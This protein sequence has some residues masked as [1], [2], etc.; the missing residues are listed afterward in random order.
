MENKFKFTYSAKEQEEIRKIRN[1]Y[2]HTVDDEDKISTLRRLDRQV[3]SKATMYSL[4]VGIIG[5]LIMGTGMSLILTDVAS[6]LGAVLAMI[7]GILIGVAGIILVCL[8]YPTYNYIIKKERAK[9]APEIIRLTDE[10]I[11]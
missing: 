3:E 6:S 5:A 10:L 11:K 7:A 9:V 2:S 4:I 1:K 8:A